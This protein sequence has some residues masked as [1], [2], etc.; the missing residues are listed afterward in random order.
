MVNSKLISGEWA[1]TIGF[2]SHT[3][4]KGAPYLIKTAAQA[5]IDGDVIDEVIN[6]TLANGNVAIRHDRQSQQITYDNTIS[7]LTATDVKDALDEIVA[8]IGGGTPVTSVFGRTGLITA[9]STDYDAFYTEEAPNDGI[10]YSR[11]NLAWS[12]VSSTSDTNYLG[13][14]VT[15]TVTRGGA[16]HN[17]IN[18]SSVG[19]V[20][21]TLDVST[22]AVGDR[23]TVIRQQETAGNI[24]IDT[25]SGTIELPDGTNAASNTMNTGSFSSEF[26]KTNTNEW[27]VR[28]Y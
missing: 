16:I 12:P 22:F 15:S 10:Q 1:E 17:I 14:L 6:W 2:T 26:T 25:D 11:K 23:V 18:R 27:R 24:T 13:D 20:A 28:V 4:G 8:T 3:D 21:Y 5:A 7:S 9:E 19:A